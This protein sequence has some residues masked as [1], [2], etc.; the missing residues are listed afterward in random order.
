MATQIGTVSILIGTAT[1]TSADGT[2]RTL[3]IGD[4]IYADDL[5]STGPSAALE[6]TFADGSLMD[7]GRSSQLVL[8]DAV[9]DPNVVAEA[10]VGTDADA[11]QQAILAGVD[12][13]L[14]FLRQ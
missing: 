7:L 4:I 10:D 8:D 13:A 3:H 6:I 5:I 12:H 11:I 2:V 9:Y 1:A 14:P